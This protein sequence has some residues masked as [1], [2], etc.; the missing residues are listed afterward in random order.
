MFRNTSHWYIHIIEECSVPCSAQ[1]VA[2][3]CKPTDVQTNNIAVVK[4]H[5]GI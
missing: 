4:L 3:M 1:D 2:E 5:M